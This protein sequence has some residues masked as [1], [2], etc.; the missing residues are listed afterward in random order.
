M[1]ISKYILCLLISVVSVM[2]VAAESPNRLKWRQVAKITDR[3]FFKTLEAERI[4]RQVLAYQRV[5]GGCPKI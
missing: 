1:K 3:D 5:T 4:A 2:S